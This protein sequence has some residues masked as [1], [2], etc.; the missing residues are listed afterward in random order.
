MKLSGVEIYYIY[1]DSL[2]SFRTVSINE[3]L[4]W[5]FHTLIII[6]SLGVILMI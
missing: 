4:A 1:D 5:C 3:R 6:E 2:S